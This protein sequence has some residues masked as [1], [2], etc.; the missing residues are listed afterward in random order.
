[1]IDEITY[2]KIVALRN[3]GFSIR[4][5]AKQLSLSPTTVQ[6]FRKMSYTDFQFILDDTYRKPSVL[7]PYRNEFIV[8]MLENPT[9]TKAEMFRTFS[10]MYP[11]FKISSRAFSAYITKIKKGMGLK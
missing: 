7:D 10:I 2:K 11:T 9:I 1:M 8:W 6:K 3:M 5:S 4:D